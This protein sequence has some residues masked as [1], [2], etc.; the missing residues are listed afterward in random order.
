MSK[1]EEKYLFNYFFRG[2]NS[3]AKMGFGLGLVLTKKILKVNHATISY[4]SSKNNLNS[5]EVK[6]PLS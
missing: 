1:L 6:F 3:K 5:F 2:I 4:R